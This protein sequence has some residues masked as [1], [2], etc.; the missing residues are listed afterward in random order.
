MHVH[1]EFRQF[2]TEQSQRMNM[3]GAGLP[4]HLQALARQL[5]E[6]FPLVLDRGIHRR[7]LLLFALELLQ[8]RS[9]LRFGDALGSWVSTTSP[10]ASAVVVVSPSFTLTR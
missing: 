1:D 4:F 2:Q 9:D 6:T 7:Q 10:S 8:E 3:D 5:V